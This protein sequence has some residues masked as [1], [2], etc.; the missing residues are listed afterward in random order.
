M[1]DTKK[2]NFAIKSDIAPVDELDPDS[3]EFDERPGSYGFWDSISQGDGEIFIDLLKDEDTRKACYD[4]IHTLSKLESA[5][6]D[7]IVW[8]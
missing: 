2:L 5:V 4:A 6:E 7:Y 3:K 8:M 1:E